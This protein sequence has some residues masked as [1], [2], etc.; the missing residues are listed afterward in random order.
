[1][2]RGD[3]IKATRGQ[4]SH[5]GIDLGDGYVI[6]FD[7]EQN[8]VTRARLND[9][10]RGAPFK[11]VPYGKA[12]FAPEVTVRLAEALVGQKSYDLAFQNC[13]H[14]ASWCKCGNANSEQVNTGAA[15]L[16]FITIWAALFLGALSEIYLAG[17]RGLHA[18]GWFTGLTERGGGFL[19]LGVI[20]QF[21]IPIAIGLLAS[22]PAYLLWKWKKYIWF[23]VYNIAVVI[24]AVLFVFQV[25]LEFSG[26]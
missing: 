18:N 26:S 19:V 21:G 17:E 9:F 15:A 5:H 6:H 3:H 11:I 2:A 25:G 14:I 4:Y 12:C 1:M 16:A 13:E 7:K 8:E 24:L 20:R 22:F 10:H 23:V